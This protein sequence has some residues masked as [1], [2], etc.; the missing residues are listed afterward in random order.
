MDEIMNEENNW[1]HMTEASM[2]E[3]LIEKVTIK[4]W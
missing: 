3:G 4:N 2:V 1:D